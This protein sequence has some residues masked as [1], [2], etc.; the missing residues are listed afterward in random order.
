MAMGLREISIIATP[1]ADRLA[2]RP[3]L[4]LRRRCS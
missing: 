2:I 1:P 3:R 4:P